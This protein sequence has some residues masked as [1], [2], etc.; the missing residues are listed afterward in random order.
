[1]NRRLFT[2]PTDRRGIAAVEFALVM[3][4][5]SLMVVGIISF[6]SALANYVDLTEG[7]RTAARVL[8][9]SSSYPSSA[10]SSAFNSGYF[11]EA[12]TNLTQSGLNW[13]VYVNGSASACNSTSSSSYASADNTACNSALSGASGEAVKV[14]ATYS[15][16]LTVLGHSYLPN[17]T[18][19]VTTSQMVE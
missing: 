19:S 13:Y 8:A 11:Q 18:I 10:Y 5:L 6:A 7:V 3:P 9:Q 1:M 16:C 14:T 17:C 4:I 12:T 2:L 15:L